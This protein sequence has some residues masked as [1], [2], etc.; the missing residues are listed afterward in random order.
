M[1]TE[2]EVLLMPPSPCLR[3]A[4]EFFCLEKACH[5]RHEFFIW[6]EGQAM[7]V[8]V[9]AVA[10]VRANGAEPKSLHHLS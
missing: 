1:V 7:A 5:T 6:R 10:H 9:R 8:Q 3:K 4:W 2:G